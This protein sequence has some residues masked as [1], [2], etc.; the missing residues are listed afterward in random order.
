M[1]VRDVEVVVLL[2]Y[3][4]GERPAEGVHRLELREADKGHFFATVF[5][6]ATYTLEIGKRAVNSAVHILSP[7]ATG[8]AVRVQA[9]LVVGDQQFQLCYVVPHD[10]VLKLHRWYVVQAQRLLAL[11][12]EVKADALRRAAALLGR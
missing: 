11:H 4:Y 8:V 1:E 9:W 6:N 7:Y 10:V 12:D 3:R 2:E 5:G